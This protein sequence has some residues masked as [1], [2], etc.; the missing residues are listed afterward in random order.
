MKA[1]ELRIYPYNKSPLTEMG[2][3][4]GDFNLLNAMIFSICKARERQKKSYIFQV[5]HEG[6]TGYRFSLT[7]QEHEQALK[8]I[9]NLK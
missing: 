7:K 6:V 8:Y 9:P 1:T 2:T 3:V 4:E 5:E